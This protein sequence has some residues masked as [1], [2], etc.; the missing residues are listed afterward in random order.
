MNTRGS[1]SALGI[2]RPRWLAAGLILLAA[3]GWT[4]AAAGLEWQPI[5]G[6]RFARLRV[7]TAGKTGFTLLGGAQTGIH[8]TNALDDRLVMQNNN[9]MEGAGVALG[10]FDRDGWCDLYFCAIDGTN[11]LYRNRGDGTFADV[12]AMAGVGAGGWHSTGAV[13]ADVDGDGR[14]DLLVNTLGRGTH[15]F[16]NLG[17]GRFREVTEEA[18]LTSQAGSLGLALADIDGDGDLDLYVANYGT[19]AILRA[20]GRAEMKQ[21]NGQWRLTGPY[22]DRLRMVEGRLEEVG[23][24]DVLYWN[25]GRGHFKPV[26]WNSEWFLDEEGR[27]MPPPWDFGLTVQ[28][29]DINE[30][31]FP[32]IYVCNDFQTVD[33]LWINDGTGH[34]HLPP[35]LAMREQSF[36]SMGVDFADVDRDGRLDFFVVEMLSREH[37]RRLRQVGGMQPSFPFP[38]RFENR[39]EVARNTLFWNRGDGTYAEIAN[40]SGLDASEWSWQPV[41]LDVDLDGFED[42]LVVNG[43]AFD[44]QD[45]DVLRQV[46]ALGQQTPEQTRSNLLLYPRLQ[47]PN[48]AFRNRGDLTF[49]ETGQAW[50]FDSRR[51]SHGIALAD[52]DQDGDLDVVVNCLYASPLVYRNDSPA[53]RVAVRLRGNA[54]NVQGLGAKIK[55]L[56]GAV[57]VQCQEII[58]GGRYLSGDDPMRVF[59]AGPATNRLRLEVTWRSGRRSVVDPVQPNCLYELDEGPGPAR[60]ISNLKSQISNRPAASFT[61]VSSLLAH[62]HHEELFN[63]Y[64]RQPLLMKQLSQLGPGV[65]W[66]DLDSDGHDDLLIG[67]GKGGQV[68]AFRG[69]GRGRFTSLSVT[70]ATPAPDDVTGLAA[71][72][73]PDGRRGMLAGIASYEGSA[74]HAAIGTWA[75][76]RASD[77]LTNALARDVPA[78]GIS[79][80]PL[81]VADYDGDGELD[82]FVGGRLVPGQYPKP[83]TSR[84]YRQRQG[85]LVLDASSQAVLDHIG[86]VSG[87]VWSDLDGDGFPELIL[88]LE[89]GPVK[90]FRNE[91]GKLTPWDPMVTLSPAARAASQLGTGDTQSKT[92]SQLTGWWNSV[93]A[94][95]LDGD[96][97]LDLIAGNWGLNSPYHAT[98]NQPVRLYWGDLGAGGGGGGG[99]A[100]DLVEAYFAR[101]LDAVVPRRALSALSQ[102]APRLAEQFPTHASFSTVSVDEVF[103]RLNVRPGEVQATTLASL[104]F[105]NRGDHFD[106]VPLPA[107]AQWAPVFAITVADFDGDGQQDVFLSQ[108]F[109]ALRPEVPRLDAGRGLLLRGR[110]GGQLEPVPGQDSGLAVYG[111]QRGAAA[112][113]FD[114][115][116]R[117][118]L[119]VTQNGSSTRLFRNV[120]GAPG[121]RVRLRGPRGNPDGIG[122]VVRVIFENA[123]G[124]AQEIHAGAGYWSQDSAI[125]VVATP[126]SPRRL[127]VRWAGGKSVQAEVPAGS[128]E[129]SVDE[130]GA[131]KVIR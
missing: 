102:A 42:L 43:N 79:S 30:D 72:V 115:D 12:T 104:V 99:G 59:A 49:E 108:N 56:G 19:Q 84:V 76:D 55:L 106:A 11:A 68:A 103:R 37:S 32:D 118:D 114:E 64:A 5:D 105:F 121:L 54:P 24:P 13:F 129:I 8:F 39:P 131:A 7:S 109:F 87:A 93:T 45:R 78:F 69:D 50:G 117:M 125:L 22:A 91:G 33:R 89:W 110:G 28:M 70:S 21:V 122:A 113:D 98:G 67:S 48:L 88:A 16:L 27:P 4:A 34:F 9:F 128:R 63:D 60:Q 15:C 101:E 77:Q 120:G 61:D 119:V 73:L 124:P 74:V 40:F 90:I 85:R 10:D 71:W 95:D 51:I 41:F 80:G 57:P 100:V 92:L 18:G 38:G 75:F 2:E 130:Q 25:D 20:G 111:E 126:Q 6:G 23:E 81:A 44:V 94:G 35:K 116:G 53:P 47:T 31:G 17:Q 127:S 58:S 65:A 62:S 52:L 66:L 36:A 82:L 14:L 123:A 29:R 46:R 107:Q 3:S 96:G 83:A 97:R 1:T 112:S 86:L 26:P